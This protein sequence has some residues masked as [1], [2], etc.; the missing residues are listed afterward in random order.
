[1]VAKRQQA[2]HD[3]ASTKA[4]YPDGHLDHV[5]DFAV[6]PH[7]VRSGKRC[8]GVG[9]V[10]CSVRKRCRRCG[11]DLEGR[12]HVFCAVVEALSARVHVFQVPFQNGIAFLHAYDVLFYPAEEEAVNVPANDCETVPR[13]NGAWGD[14]LVR[15]RARGIGAWRGS[16]SGWREDED[17]VV[18][19]ETRCLVVR[20]LDRAKKAFGGADICEFFLR[21]VAAVVVFDLRLHETEWCWWWGFAVKEKRA[22]KGVIPFQGPVF[23]HDAYP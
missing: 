9:D 11:E 19:V 7:V 4:E 20:G 17:V 8:N 14:E 10:V 22:E 12:V 18:L 21:Q 16:L 1:M 23:A 15:G 13:S 3:G 6:R 2:Q 5:A